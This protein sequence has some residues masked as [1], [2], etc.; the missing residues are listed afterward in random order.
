[1]PDLDLDPG[2]YT[3]RKPK[4]W[5]WQLPWGHPEDSKLHMTLSVI[6]A[7]FLVFFYFQHTTLSTDVALLGG[8]VLGALV[9]GNLV[10]AFRD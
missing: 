6:C 8:A 7:G 2:S 1:M 9:A 10:L 4:G 5:R 3:E